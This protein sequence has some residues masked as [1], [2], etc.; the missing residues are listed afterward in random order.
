MG[1]R[2]KLNYHQ[3][4]TGQDSIRIDQIGTRQVL[5]ARLYLKVPLKATVNLKIISLINLIYFQVGLLMSIMSAL[6]P[7]IIRSYHLTYGVASTLPFA[8][9]ISF[10]FV[11]IPAGIQ[12]ENHPTKN[13]LL[14]SFLLALVGTLLFA[15]N[16]T[17]YASV[18]SLFIIGSAVAVIQV[19]VVPLL[20]QVCGAENL[21]FHSSLNQLLYGAGAFA[22]P[23]VYSFLTRVLIQA[24][25]LPNSMI[26]SLRALVP[27]GFEWV[28]AYWLFSVILIMLFVTI[29]FVKFPKELKPSKQAFNWQA[30]LDFLSNKYVYL[31]FVA[32]TAYASCEQGIAVWMSKFFQDYHQIDPVA[33]GAAILSWYWVLLS[34]GCVAG[35][36][37][38]KLF[39]S[40]YV[41]ATFSVLA[42]LFFSLGLYGS[43]EMSRFSF[44]LVGLFESIMW[45]VVLSLAL[46]SVDKNHSMLTGFLYTASIGGALGPFIIG[47]LSDKFQLRPSLNYIYLPLLVVLSV[48]FWAKPLVLNKT[49]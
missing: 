30:Y 45:P 41:L 3:R 5:S 48:A 39:D 7:E 19:S 1:V 13:V 14:F 38:V 17:Y 42:I 20:L 2:C 35:M 24:G 34:C 49:S 25:T 27:K 12:N 21:A 8:F 6:I 32:L 37:L 26:Y 47:T 11:C 10:G 33:S 29:W 46:N 18:A 31:Y 16:P 44:P 15:F 23:L 40:R 28:A 9:Y 4:R 36:L 43:I 22:S